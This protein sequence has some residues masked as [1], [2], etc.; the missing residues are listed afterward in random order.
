LLCELADGGGF[1]RS[2]HAYD[3]NNSHPSAGCPKGGGGGKPIRIR[4]QNL[5]QR[6]LDLR[7]VGIVVRAK[8]RAQFL[9]AIRGYIRRDVGHDQ[10][11][12]HRIQRRIV[13]ALFNEQRLYL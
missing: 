1:S 12:Q 10:R 6:E 7:L 13:K 4:A 8:F 5:H 11:V 2:V 3:Q 9:N